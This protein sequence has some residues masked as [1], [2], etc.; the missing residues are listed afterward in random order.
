MNISRLLIAALA[1]IS[2]LATAAPGFVRISHVSTV[3]GKTQSPM[4]IIAAVGETSTMTIRGDA[5]RPEVLLTLKPQRIAK[6]ILEKSRQGMT[7]EM[8]VKINERTF[9]LVTNTLAKDKEISDRWRGFEDIADSRHLNNRVEREVVD[10]L[11]AAVRAADV[12]LARST[13]ALLSST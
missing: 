1:S 5:S 8:P 6:V 4:N 13:D 9:A 12:L 10:A 3:G 7:A 11:V 2:T